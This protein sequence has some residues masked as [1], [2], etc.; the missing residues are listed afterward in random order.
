MKCLYCKKREAKINYSDVFAITH[1]FGATPLCR[2]CYIKKI[3]ETIK[4]LQ[5][6]LKEQKKILRKEQF[7]EKKDGIHS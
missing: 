5:E 2:Q 1:G 4:K 3:E 6:N 7:M